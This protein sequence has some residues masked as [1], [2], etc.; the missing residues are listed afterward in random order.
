MLSS[1][2]IENLAVIERV[3]IDFEKGF[4]VFT[5]ETGA[6]K[7]ILIDAINACLGQRAS[8]EIVRNHT[9]KAVISA[10]FIHLSLE[11]LA[12]LEKNGYTPEEELVITREIYADGRSSARIN[13]RP[14]TVG[15]LRELGMALINIHGQHDNQILLSPERHLSLIDHYGDLLSFVQQYETEFRVLSRMIRKLREV[16]AKEAQKEEQKRRLTEEWDQIEK[17][18]LSEGIDVIL[19]EKAALFRN[20]EK[21]ASGL[22]EAVGALYGDDTSFGAVDLV[23]RAAASLLRLK[24]I[25]SLA[26]AS[27]KF[28]S[29]SIEL[30]AAAG[31]LRDLLDAARYDPAQ[32]EEIE[33]RLSRIRKLKLK[34]GEIPKILERKAILQKELEELDQNGQLLASLTKETRVQKEKVSLL[35]RE[36]T[37]RRKEAANRLSR[38]IEEEARFLEMPALRVEPLF[39]PTKLN[40]SG[41]TSVELML[42]SNPGEPPKPIAKIAS[43]GELSRIMLAIKSAL[44][45]KDS[46]PTLIFDEIDTGVSGKAAQKIGRKLKEVSK[47]RQ[48]FSVTHSAQ[49]AALAH[50]H[51]LIQKRSEEN[52]TYTTVL[53]LTGEDRVEE[54]ARI[55]S[56]DAVSDLMRETARSMLKEGNQS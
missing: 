6:G 17:A 44:A 38:R 27:E 37:E 15:M 4:T 12:I 56:T 18:K 21:I 29:L 42:S 5:G 36:L 32:A 30:E 48:V 28:N 14:A 41:D 45:E 22:S 24:D 23:S 51:F 16:T 8:R 50:H 47:S 20:G 55:F 46:I 26:G 33:N 34:Y 53:P 1:L 39:T 13:G 31:D 9:E 54:V 11:A 25:P 35:A 52:R 7:S 43:G 49:I 10:S 19:E 3:S 2:Y 40:S